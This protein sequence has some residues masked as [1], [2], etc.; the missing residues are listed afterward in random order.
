MTID[1]SL[2]ALIREEMRPLE[3]KLSLMASLIQQL[4][5]EID[6]QTGRCPAHTT[7]MLA[8]A[9]KRGNST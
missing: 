2:R 5:Q 3:I 6:Q 1:D 9:A 8:F 7:C 4:C